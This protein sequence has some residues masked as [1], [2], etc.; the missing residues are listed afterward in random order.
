MSPKTGDHSFLSPYLNINKTR[1]IFPYEHFSKSGGSSYSEGQVAL[2]S[3]AFPGYHGNDSAASAMLFQHPTSF[4]LYLLLLAPE[5]FLPTSTQEKFSSLA[6]LAPPAH[7]APPPFI[8][9]RTWML[10]GGGVGARVHHRTSFISSVKVFSAFKV[11][12]FLIREGQKKK[13]GWI[14]RVRRKGGGGL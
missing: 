4:P 7:P 12:W 3:L 6:N 8:L 9:L 13:G 5:L 11:L 1:K 2:R 10:E 14:W